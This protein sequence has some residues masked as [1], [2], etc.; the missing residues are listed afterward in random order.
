MQFKDKTAVI[1]GGNSGI[2]LAAAKLLQERGAKVAICGRNPNTLAEAQAQ[3]GAMLAEVC[4]IT[5]SKSIDAFLENVKSKFKKIDMLVVNSGIGIFANV[6]E[7]KPELWDQVHDINLKGNFFAAQKSLE[8]MHKGSSIVFTGSI[9]GI[10]GLPGNVIYAAAKAG[11]RAVVR[12]MAKELVAEG[13]RVNMVSPGPT[14]TPII[15]RNVD[16]PPEAVDDL[17][18]AM[19]EA[20]PMKRMGEAGEVAKAICFL[21]SDDASFV[22]GIDFFADGG[23]VE[24]G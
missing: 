7:V 16:M 1:F 15:N 24:I 2:G 20:V 3:S 22:T 12:N 19:I 23:C 11:L 14:E 13:I 21:V 10:L 17:R 4:D 9:G 8:L 18:K 6:R 5:N